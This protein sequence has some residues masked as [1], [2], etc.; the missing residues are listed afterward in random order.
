VKNW[1]LR[2]VLVSVDMMA[3]LMADTMVLLL[4]TQTVEKMAILL[5]DMMVLLLEM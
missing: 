4:E 3:I 2:L 1:A 5:V